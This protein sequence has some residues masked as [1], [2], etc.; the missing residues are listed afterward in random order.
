MSQSK[1]Q[2]K[3]RLKELQ[4]LLA[5][6]ILVLDGPTGTAIQKYQ[7][8]ED[9]YRG[10]RF[11]DYAHPLQG[12]NDLLN[13]TQPQIMTEILESYLAAGADFV[14][15]NT[16]NATLISQADYYFE[17]DVVREINLAGAKISRDLADK[18]TK[19]TPE[20]PRYVYGVLG[21]TNRTASISPEVNNPAARN[22]TFLQLAES[23]TQAITALHDGGV[24]LIMM[25]TVFDTLNAKAAIFA[26]ADFCEKMMLSCL[27]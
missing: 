24:D 7:L 26:H 21:P 10:A 27:S 5:K 6:R 13:I 11:A 16:F 8:S 19:L 4:D 25:E 22:V 18:Y 14:Q 3:S 23:Y 9:D 17:A 15:T 2:T 1:S 12:N 20:K